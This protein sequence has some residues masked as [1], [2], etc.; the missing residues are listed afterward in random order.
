MNYLRFQQNCVQL[1]HDTYVKSGPLKAR[2]LSLISAV[3]FHETL[4]VVK[5]SEVLHT[6]IEHLM[7]P[8]DHFLGSMMSWELPPMSKASQDLPA[9][10]RKDYVFVNSLEKG[11]SMARDIL[12]EL[13]TKNLH[14]E[15]DLDLNTSLLLTST[16]KELLRISDVTVEEIIT[17][18]ICLHPLN[19]LNQL[20]Q[21][22]MQ[23]FMVFDGCSYSHRPIDAIYPV[24]RLYV[25]VDGTL[26]QRSGLILTS[27]SLFTD[28]NM[29]RHVMTRFTHPRTSRCKNVFIFYADQESVSEIML[30]NIVSSPIR[31]WRNTQFQNQCFCG[32][33]SICNIFDRQ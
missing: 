17:Q 24:C 11:H 5:V 10:I 7:D 1:G 20:A 19:L 32:N 28:Q 2:L 13:R 16:Y 27:P 4:P 6:N 30:N 29:F 14:F 33:T 23:I 8:N 21:K 12:H 26:D 15:L 22:K 31:G 3:R 9:Q 25:C 18:W